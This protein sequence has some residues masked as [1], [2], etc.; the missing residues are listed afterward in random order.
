MAT[1]KPPKLSPTELARETFRQ[2]SI[3]RTSP[4]PDAYRKLY[5]EIAGIKEE[6][7]GKTAKAR[8]NQELESI[9]LN[10]A[11]SLTLES[12]E[13]ASI[14]QQLTVSAEQSK[15]NEYQQGLNEFIEKIFSQIKALQTKIRNESTAQA[16]DT[17][18]DEEKQTSALKNLLTRTLGLALPSL[19]N[20]APE[21]S[22][23]SEALSKLL[24]KA[25]SEKQLAEVESRLKNLCFK[26]EHLAKSAPGS[27]PATGTESLPLMDDPVIPML[28]KLLSQTLGMAVGTLLQHEPKL[29]EVSDRLADD[30]K[31]ARSMD[32]FLRIESSLK[33]LCYKITLKGDDASEQLQLLLTLF[34]LLLENVSSLLD[35][36]NWLRGQVIIIKELIDGEIDHRALLEATKDRKSVV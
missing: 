10:F 7:E 12:K 21:L 1:A 25:Q 29:L 32:D 23:E 2:L 5:N 31:S 6:P 4:T 9:L 22:Q 28:S 24:K 14:G 3:N 35:D 26:I 33:D 34:K 8:N 15:W 36:D 19:L 18:A 17:A 16:A 13:Y 11:I 20:T 30:V 27:V